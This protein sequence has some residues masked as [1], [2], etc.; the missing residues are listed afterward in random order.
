MPIVFPINPANGQ[1]YVSGNVTYIWTTSKNAWVVTATTVAGPP[2]PVGAQGFQGPRGFQGFQGA[3]GFQGFQGVQGPQGIDTASNRVLKAGD[4]MTGNL[5]VNATIFSQNVIPVTN[6]VYSLGTPTQR[7]KDLWLS[8]STIFL[9]DAQISSNGNTIQLGEATIATIDPTGAFKISVGNTAQRPIANASS[10][11][12]IRFNTT[13]TEPEWYDGANSQ[14][15][16]FSTGRPSPPITIEYMIIAGGGGG[17]NDMG[18]GGGA[19]GYLTGNVTVF[20]GN[21]YVIQIGAGGTGAPAGTGGA[22]GNTGGNTTAFGVTAYGGGGGASGHTG[23][24][25]AADNGGSGGGASGQYAN[26]GVGVYP[27]STFRSEARQGYDGANSIGAW[28]PGGGGGSAGAGLVNIASGGPGTLNPIL[29]SNYYWAG[30][31]GGGGYSNWGGNGGIGGGGGGAP[32]DSNPG[33]TGKGGTSAINNGSDATVGT[34]GSQ[35]NVPGGNAGTNTGSGGG[36][37]SHYNS[38]NYGGNGGSGIVVVRYASSSRRLIGGTTSS[39]T[40]NGVIYWAHM[41]TGSGE[42]VYN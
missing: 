31:G 37:G 26:R 40:S 23:P 33:S 38:N 41:F 32:R 12:M 29:G 36:G 10:N 2:G 28:Y 5:N 6:V 16:T 19:G 22:R 25:V 34:T 13:L 24:V 21:T 20:G 1:Q 42:L 3:Q 39:Y 8:N 35:T 27:G 14:W 9:G 18:G 17:G 11:G 4:T 30:G 7:F 15:Y